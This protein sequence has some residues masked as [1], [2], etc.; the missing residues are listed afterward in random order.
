MERLRIGMLAKR[1]GVNLETI[2]Y[3]ERR[4]LLPKP[5][6]TAS[7]YRIFGE[8]AVKRVHFI[9]RAQ[10]LGFS[11]KEIGDL[12]VL[13]ADGHRSC[14]DVLGR[15]IAKIDDIESKICALEQ[16][17]LALQTISASCS[18]EGPV[19]EC[20]I[21]EYFDLHEGSQSNTEGESKWHLQKVK[22]TGVPTR[23]AG[24]KSPS[25]KAPRREREVTK[26]PAAVAAKK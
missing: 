11:L 8:D 16:L 13:R 4:Q 23:R 10:D 1:G 26:R 20:P 12:L 7:G 5:P 22:S 14:T 17:E 25:P 9:K 21:L 6:R 18:G 24:A 15:V 2:R 19:S 3:Y